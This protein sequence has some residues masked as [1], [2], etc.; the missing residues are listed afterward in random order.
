[1][2]ALLRLVLCGSWQ[3]CLGHEPHLRAV[4]Q[5]VAGLQRPLHRLLRAHPQTSRP[6]AHQWHAHVA[7]NAHLRQAVISVS[8]LKS[9][10]AMIILLRTSHSSSFK[11]HL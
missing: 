7:G 5:S 11:H 6:I 1:M 3:E 2:Q 8:A 10:K 4:E 9:K